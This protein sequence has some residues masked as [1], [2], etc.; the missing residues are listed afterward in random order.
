MTNKTCRQQNVEHS[1]TSATGNMFSYFGCCNV[2][3]V[4]GKYFGCRNVTPVTGH[5]F[6]YASKT[7]HYILV[8]HLNSEEKLP[9]KPTSELKSN[10][11]LFSATKWRQI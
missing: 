10:A 2:T 3:P 5:V 8:I 6:A 9:K 7:F 11:V 4:T 1:L